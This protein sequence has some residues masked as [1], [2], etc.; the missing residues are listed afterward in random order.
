MQNFLPHRKT[1]RAIAA[2]LILAT[3]L[4]SVHAGGN[5]VG[6][7]FTYQGQLLDQNAPANGT[8]NMQF[9]VYENITGGPALASD[10]INGVQVVRGLFSVEVNLGNGPFNGN[11][12]WLETRIQRPGEPDFTVLTPRQRF[13]S[14]PYAIQAQFAENALFHPWTTFI[15]GIQ[16]L[17]GQVVVGSGFES[18]ARLL[19][20]SG[21]AEDAM[22]VMVGNITRLRVASNGGLAV[23]S[24]A[25]PPAAGLQVNGPVRQPADRHG[26]AKAGFKMACGS[27]PSMIR[28]FN[29]VND[30]P[31]NITL[32][33][34]TPRC[35]VQLPFDASDAY[36]SVNAPWFTP[37]GANFITINASCFL[38]NTNLVVCVAE[39]ADGTPITQ[40][41]IEVMVF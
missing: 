27:S 13:N 5:N 26:F 23:G 32:G 28:S 19:V 21:N 3:C 15:G 30:D 8:Y 33:T 18:E 20:H 9:T 37:D 22:H 31:L 41:V 38:G 6:N 2:L 24:I 7:R 1:Q 25:E 17:G 12:V 10:I 36:L 11:E 14:T 40:A 39:T 29:N 35:I 4:Q 34:N 16:R